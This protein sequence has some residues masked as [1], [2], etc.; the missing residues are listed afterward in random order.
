[1]I[2]L[3]LMKLTRFSPLILFLLLLGICTSGNLS[4]QDKKVAGGL[5]NKFKK[6]KSGPRLTLSTISEGQPYIGI[7]E[8]Q[9]TLTGMSRSFAL[10]DLLQERPILRNGDLLMPVLIDYPFA[11][12]YAISGVISSAG[13]LLKFYERGK[14]VAEHS[15][16]GDDWGTVWGKVNTWLGGQ[17]LVLGKKEK[18]EVEEGSSFH[19]LRHT[20]IRELMPG[21]D[22]AIKV[23]DHKVIV[24]TSNLNLDP[25]FRN[26][27]DDPYEHLRKVYGT[28]FSY[29]EKELYFFDGGDVPDDAKKAARPFV[30]PLY[31][32]PRP[33]MQYI[34]TEGLFQ[35]EKD[36][37]A[38]Y[39][40]CLSTLSSS[41]DIYIGP[42]E[43][44]LIRQ[45]AFL[46][47]AQLQKAISPDRKQTESLFLFA[48]RV[49]GI[50]ATDMLSIAD[51]KKYYDALTPLKEQL[52]KTT[53]MAYKIKG[54]R[55]QGIMGAAGAFMG[56]MGSSMGGASQSISQ[57][58]LSMMQSTL[59][60]TLNTTSVMQQK[61]NDL[62]RGMDRNVNSKSFL[63]GQGLEVDF[64]KP[65]VAAEVFYHLTR[66]PELLKDPLGEYSADK[67]QLYKLLRE[68][69]LGKKPATVIPKIYEQFV[70]IEQAVLNYEGRNKTV[71]QSV[72]DKF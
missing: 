44:A 6:P 1:M 33:A 20:P 71:P 25:W 61:I 56:G 35:K 57:S 47:M 50:Y 66:H 59:N 18:I 7:S 34:G 19:I 15:F 65:L 26:T 64:G 72:L 27:P 28:Y 51:S 39:Q 42:Q 12:P 60:Q 3:L 37:G 29:D 4:A 31:R 63:A 53:D 21:A 68:F 13:S 16:S 22:M 58:Y 5:L 23:L 46:R 52:T 24:T 14:K 30:F 62:F 48:S 11:A 45:R 41:D 36:L 40:A 38:A 55:F 17:P 70:F 54:A 10:Y 9:D 8:L 49:N 69:Y 43:Q 2:D 67:P 32:T